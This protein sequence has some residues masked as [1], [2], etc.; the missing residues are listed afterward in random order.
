MDY[1]DFDMIRGANGFN[2]RKVEKAVG[3]NDLMPFSVHWSPESTLLCSISSIFIH[4][5]SSMNVNPCGDS[6]QIGSLSNS[7][8]T[9][10]HSG[11]V[12][13]FCPIPRPINF[14][15]KQRHPLLSNR[16]AICSF[17]KACSLWLKKYPLM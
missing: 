10:A 5:T 3:R 13:N 1:H 11:G 7:E 4:P 8:P 2:D 16:D 9:G 6:E 12:Q 17:F 15:R 14:H